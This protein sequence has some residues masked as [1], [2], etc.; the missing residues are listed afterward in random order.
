MRRLAA[1]VLAVLVVGWLVTGW[2]GG[3][4][5]VADDPPA[6]PMHG[7]AG[8]AC[9]HCHEDPHAAAA[10]AAA[11]GAAAAA[12]TGACQ[13][14]H[15]TEA[16]LP[17]TFTVDQHASTAFPLEGK[18]RAVACGDCHV[19][20]A[21][22]GLPTTCAE[23]HVDRHRGKLGG[24][25][26]TCHSTDGF[27]PVKLAFDHEARTGFALTGAHGFTDTPD[28][29]SCD[30]CH[31]G[32]NGRAMRVVATATC[33]TC[34]APS[35]GDFG[36]CADCHAPIRPDGGA[37]LFAGATFDHRRNTPFPLERRHAAQACGTCHPVAAPMPDDRC[38]SC[39]SDV[40]A[41]QLG[42]ACADCHRADR[43]RVVRFDHDR[44][45]FPLTGRHF[46]APCTSCHTSQRW[47]GLRAE[48]WDCHAL[49]VRR[50]P[51]TVPAHTVGLADC[52]ACHST[53]SWATR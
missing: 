1:A 11:A 19:D 42:T 30:R 44:T 10:A 35:H 45:L 14:C 18:H 24:D 39:H 16:W 5:A 36:P 20:H 26:T 34:H 47:I 41:G 38:Q 48:C 28:S 53:W 50:A 43:W 31:K 23:C 29:R 27:V 33:E 15:G 21:L 51:A 8:V 37:G 7:P 9:A 22:K 52:R 25:C 6:M 46:V 13:D 12:P 17:T 3:R 32:D 2:P 40:H 4:V 49:D